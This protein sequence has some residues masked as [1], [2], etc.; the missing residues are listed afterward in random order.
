[1]KGQ[2]IYLNV[3]WERAI[4][5]CGTHEMTLQLHAEVRFL[6]V[7]HQKSFNSFTSRSEVESEKRNIVSQG[8]R[9]VGRMKQQDK[10]VTP[11]G[12]ELISKGFNG[13]SKPRK[14]K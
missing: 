14:L 8:L 6:V 10:T 5:I 9:G 13:R 1:M 4:F 3:T 2:Q 7:R 11:V 12:L